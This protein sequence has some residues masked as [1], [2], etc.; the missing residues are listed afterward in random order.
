MEIVLENDR[1]SAKENSETIRS[2]SIKNITRVIEVSTGDPVFAYEYDFYMFE[3]GNE[4]W[5]SETIDFK[6]CPNRS[7]NWCSFENWC[8]KQKIRYEITHFD[9]PPKAFWKKRFFIKYASVVPGIYDKQLV[10]EI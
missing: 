4:F 2:E 8:S 1:I 10:T 7:E 3:I 6:N 5:V 9:Y